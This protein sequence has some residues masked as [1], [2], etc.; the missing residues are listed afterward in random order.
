MI[1]LSSYL[2]NVAGAFILAATLICTLTFTSGC[3]SSGQ[4]TPGTN[5]TTISQISDKLQVNDLVTIAISGVPK[6]PPIH[7]ERIKEDGTLT[8]PLIGTYQALNKTQS[9]IQ[10]ELTELYGKY[11]TGH[12]VTVASEGRYI[13]I[14]GEVRMP[15]K[16]IYVPGMTFLRAIAVAGGYSTFASRTRVRVTHADGTSKVVNGRSIERNPSKDFPILPGDYIEVP[17]R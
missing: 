10:T 3:I 14:N 13:Y 7:A 4:N 16:A 9:E 8:L 5:P 15:G 17:K 1:R 2:K 11:Y 12:V 6:P